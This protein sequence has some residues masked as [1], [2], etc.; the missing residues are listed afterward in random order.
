MSLLLFWP[1]TISSPHEP[2]MLVLDPYQCHCTSQFLC[3]L[4]KIP[5]LAHST[6]SVQELTWFSIH[7]K[8]DPTEP[9]VMNLPVPDPAAPFSGRGSSVSRC[10]GCCPEAPQPCLAQAMVFFHWGQCGREE[11]GTG[12]PQASSSTATSKKQSCSDHVFSHLSLFFI[13]A[14]LSL[15]W[16]F[17]N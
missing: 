17:C 11:P 14:H 15:F 8:D 2:R 12:V 10:W 9:L 3:K 7:L 6:T 4:N 1:N 13:S 5:I 16:V